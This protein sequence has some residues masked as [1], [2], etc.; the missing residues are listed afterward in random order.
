MKGD[1]RC[2]T[3]DEFNWSNWIDK[4][5]RD[6]TII[7]KHKVN[8]VTVIPFASIK[9][10]DLI[11]LRNFDG[12]NNYLGTCGYDKICRSH[13]GVSTYTKNSGEYIN[14]YPTTGRWRILD[15]NGSSTNINELN[16][17]H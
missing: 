6:P 13:Q 2:L 4:T 16:Y 11:T 14:T 17:S 10:G 5:K 3:E 12:V 7:S 1:N 8:A 15:S 9:Y